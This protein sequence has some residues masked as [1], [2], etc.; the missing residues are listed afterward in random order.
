LAATPLRRTASRLI[1]WISDRRVPRMLR[2]PIYRGYARVYDV[3]LGELRLPLEEHPSFTAFFVRRLADGARRFP[4]DPALL[5]SPCD[6]TLQASDP[7]DSGS[8]LQAK[9][10]PYPV[11]ELL[12]GADHEVE[13]EGGHAWTIYLSPRDYHRVHAPV[14]ASLSEIRWQPGARYSVAPKVLAARPKVL[15][16]NERAVLR[17]ETAR[18]P[19]FLVMVGALNVG[20]IRVVGAETGRSGSLEP[21]RKFARGDDLARFE[22]GSTVVLVAPRGGPRPVEGLA[23]G[24]RIRMGDVIGR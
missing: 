2:A 12:A 7:V 14:D 20:R 21:P 1:G 6:G 8:I 5:P 15:S 13:L 10:R 11:R 19:L 18:G 16:I 9:G 23:L 4:L 24:Q 17:L 3:D 22:M